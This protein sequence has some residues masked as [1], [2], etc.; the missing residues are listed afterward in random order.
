[1]ADKALKDLLTDERFLNYCFNRNSEDKQY[2]ENWLS[3]HPEHRE[4]VEALR[5]T[6]LLLAGQTRERVISRHYVQLQQTINTRRK[7]LFQKLIISPWA[8]AALFL[9]ATATALYF[10]T[11][12]FVNRKSTIV[13]HEILPGHNQATLTLADGRKV[14]LD[15]GQ[16]GIIVQDE[17]IKYNNGRKIEGVGHKAEGPGVP[18]SK[19]SPK[20]GEMLN[21]VQHD[22]L[23][24]LSTPKGGQYQIMLPDGTKVWL[25][26]ATTLKYP[27]RFS[28][29][30]REVF[31]EGEALFEVNNK[32]AGDRVPRVPFI[33]K[34]PKQ[35][36]LV[37]A[38]SFNL[39]AYSNETSEKTTLVEGKVQVRSENLKRKTYNIQLL[40]SKQQAVVT[41]DSMTVSTVDINRETAWK[42]GT[43]DF[44]GKNLEQVMKELSRWYNIEVVYKNQQIPSMTF[45]GTMSRNNNLSQVLEILKTTKVKF[46]VEGRKLII[47]N[48]PEKK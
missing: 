35:E 38:T 16:S 15:S 44:T 7:T 42:N 18:G 1:M 33:V 14:A 25:N 37:L 26:A 29:N 27:N 45:V 8:Y 6:V 47:N 2:W 9:L 24:Q 41:G 43:F 36:V 23:L 46:N 12:L 20:S 4:E 32:T 21:Q 34:T 11:S 39:S 19:T 28:G 31:L 13:I 30:T 10:N 5:H 40:K 17:D 48:Q 22:A 3:S